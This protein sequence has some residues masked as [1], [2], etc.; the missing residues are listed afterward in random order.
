[1]RLT[2]GDRFIAMDGQHH[3]WLTQLDI[4][5]ARI[6]EPIAVST[7]LPLP[8]TVLT[9]LPKGNLFDDVVRQATELGVSTIVPMI[10]D[11]TL[12]QPSA[13]KLE[14]WRRIAQ[15]AAE[16]S[17]RLVIPTLL[18][19]LPFPVAIAHPA[20]TS[21][22]YLCITEHSAPHLLQCLQQDLQ[23]VA[24]SHEQSTLPGSSPADLAVA[25][26]TGPEGGWSD[27][28]IQQAIAAGF[29]PV[30]LGA[31]ILRAVTAPVVALALIA[32]T[33]EREHLD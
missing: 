26:A 5:T 19:P 29:Q 24:I 27:T 28:E 22:R 8:I 7:E 31:R 33:L 12:L 11:R 21:H 14:R 30:S 17:Q 16:Q 23:Q 2:I 6:L 32:A 15:E 4:N 25:I 20:T 1:L 9:A 10:S 13:Q 18:D 3:W